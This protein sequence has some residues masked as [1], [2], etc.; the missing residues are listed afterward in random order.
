VRFTVGDLLWTMFMAA[1]ACAI[2]R[3]PSHNLVLFASNCCFELSVFGFWFALLPSRKKFRD[4]PQPCDTSCK[5]EPTSE[6][7]PVG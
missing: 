7:W 4:E 1:I 2:S 5:S 3:L 6:D